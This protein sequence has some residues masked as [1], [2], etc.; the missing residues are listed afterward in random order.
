MKDNKQHGVIYQSE[1][2]NMLPALPDLIEVDM[3]DFE[4]MQEDADT[5]MLG[6]RA[7]TRLHRAARVRPAK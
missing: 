1:D 3:T 4:H 7:S 2:F 5:V 6:F